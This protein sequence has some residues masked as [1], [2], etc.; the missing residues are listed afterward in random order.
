MFII[1]WAQSVHLNYT[2]DLINAMY[3]LQKLPNQESFMFAFC[4]YIKA[5]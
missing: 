4:F 3:K 2:Q 5:W 1:L